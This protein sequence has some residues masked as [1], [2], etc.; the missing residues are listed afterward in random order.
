MSTLYCKP[1]HQNADFCVENENVRDLRASL[2]GCAV[3][4][5]KVYHC[6]EC[7]AVYSFNGGNHRSIKNHMTKKY[8]TVSAVDTVDPHAVIPIQEDS[9]P[10]LNKRDNY[11]DEDDDDD[12]DGEDE[13]CQESF[14]VPRTICHTS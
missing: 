12:S 1:C 8:A 7:H 2:L 5:V 9:C 3:Y 6:G 10:S 14:F 11:D 4:N 13:T